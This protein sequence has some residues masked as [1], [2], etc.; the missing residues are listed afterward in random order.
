MRTSSLFRPATA[1]VSTVLYLGALLQSCSASG[2]SF[3]PVAQPDLDLKPL[4]QVAFTGDFDAVSFYSFKEQSETASVKNGS[5]SILTPLPNGIITTLS[6]S[7]GYIQAMCPFTQKDGTYAGIFVGGNFTS[8]GG[9]ETQG[10]ALFNPDTKRVTALPGLS[11]S[12]SAVLCDKETNRVYVGGEFKYE[13]TSNAVA[14]VGNEG[15][16]SLVFGGFN[17]PVT[18]ISKSTDDH[19]IF[20]GSF[21]GIG[22]S[23]SSKKNQQTV[24]IQNATITSDAVSSKSGY[25][26]PRNI[27]CQTS[28]DDGEGK[29]WLLADN[30]PGYWRADMRFGYNPTKIRL[31]NTHL[32][33]RGTKNFLLRRLPDNGIMNLTYTDPDTAED[34][35]CD[36]NCL[37]SDKK[38]EKY[39]EFKFVNSVGMKGFQIEV[40]TW[41]GDGAGLNGIELLQDDIFAYAIND[42][43]EPTCADLKY[44]SKATHS[45]SWTSTESDQSQSDYLT[46]KV[47]DST[48]SDT[49]VVFEPD[50]KQSGNYSVVVYTPGCT[51]DGTCGSRG[52]VNVTATLKSN[53]KSAEPIQKTIHQTNLND[54][55]DTLYTGHVD[56]SDGSFRPSVT[57]TPVAGQGDVTIVASRVKFALIRASDGLDGE[58]NGLYDFDPAAKS[59]NA[60]F[61]QS[62]VNRAGLQL[63]ENATVRSLVFHDGVMYAG[64]NFSSSGIKNILAL[65]D[66][67]NATAM[68]QGGLNSE[69]AS[70]TVLDD[71]LYVGGNFT[72]TS[73][74]SNSDLKHVA[75]YSFG[76][77]TWSALGGGVNGPVYKVTSLTLNISTELNETTIAVS[78]DFNQLLAFDDNPLTNVTGFAVWVPSRKNWLPN[79]NVTQMAFTGQLS[80]CTKVDNTTVIAGTLS[81]AGIAAAGAANLL[82]EGPLNIKPLFANANFSGQTYAGVYDTSSKRNLTI[83]GGHFT[84]TGSDGSSVKNLALVDGKAGTIKGLGPGADSNSTFLALTVWKDKLYAGGNVTGTVGDSNLNGFI[85]YDLQN[86]TIAQKQ[87]PRFTGGTVTVNSIAARPDSNEIYFG[88]QFEKAGA[89]PCPG[90][91]L[92]DAAEHQW[93]RPGATLAGDVLALKWMSNKKLLAVGNLT[94][95]GNSSV[96]AT[97]TPKKQSWESWTIASEIP[98]TVTAFTPAS[99]DV[100][101][102]WLAGAST[103]G[104]GFLANYDGS[105]FQYAGD[106]FGKGTTIRSL[107][108]LPLSKDHSDVSFLHDDQIL[109]VT[110]QLV[111]PNFGNASAALFNGTDLTPFMLSLDADGQPGSMAQLFYEKENPYSSE[112]G[113]HRSNGIVV[114]ISFC[115]ALGAVFLIVIAGVIFNKIQRR[116]QG[117]MPGP[118]AYGTDRPSSMRRLPPEYL[119]STLKSPNPG[120]PAI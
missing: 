109:L 105:K 21:D 79:L 119:F 72:D 64:G 117:Y 100:S 106:I 1:G 97:Y 98:G 31:Y 47:S 62:A 28:G 37:L 114:L 19:V 104:S 110:G 76:S 13:N 60:N 15:W 113:K 35:Y 8:L 34:V 71:L 22:N 3:T 111:I 40:L 38:D 12:V 99:V 75:A 96:I 108:V 82:H 2:L 67:G 66:E 10:A 77:K 56:S 27:I 44:P 33:G 92:Y 95:E 49:S 83:L 118:Q 74:R 80:A 43:N 89:L 41:Y 120:T 16:K 53:S 101:N 112:V 9:V 59:T 46:A 50:V 52:I 23:T 73:D 42:F 61:T 36:Q 88:G 39:R 85:I 103:N 63:D 116:R 14:W 20:G 5:Q 29:T 30:S 102:F 93:N 18:T 86:G 54:K 57:I 69:V 90:V 25:S 68:Q 32:D 26:D 51:Q 4:G 6:T 94:I 115:C 84:T 81:S 70:M 58:L 78:G 107:E 87:P 17:G 65:K 24:N 91:C 11:G 45:G 7:D 55:Y 48:A